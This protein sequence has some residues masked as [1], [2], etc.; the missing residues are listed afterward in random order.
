MFPEDYDLVAE[1]DPGEAGEIDSDDDALEMPEE[2]AAIEGASEMFEE[3][4]G[5]VGEAEVIQELSGDGVMVEIDGEEWAVYPDETMARM[6][7]EERVREDIE[8]DPSMFDQ[9]FIRQYASMGATDI[10]VTSSDLADSD[11]EAAMDNGEVD[12]DDSEAQNDYLSERYEE[13]QNALTE[14]PRAYLVDELG[15]GDDDWF[16]K[17]WP[18][19][20]DVEKAAGAAVRTDGIAHFLSGYDGEQVESGKSVWY[21]HN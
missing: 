15:F 19:A 13:H 6:A 10:R 21:R 8:E 11:L 16:F 9:D 20:I 5:D 4:G 12:S 17:T 2:L 14:D 18:N 1:E 7:A 3:K